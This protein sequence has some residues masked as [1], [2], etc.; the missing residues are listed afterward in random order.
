[1][2]SSLL[3][4]AL[5]GLCRAD[6]ISFPSLPTARYAA[7]TPIST[8]PGEVVFPGSVFVTPVAS[9]PQI[10][11]QT[12]FI[13]ADWDVVGASIGIKTNGPLD[14]SVNGLSLDDVTNS[15]I[16]NDLF[17]VHS[18]VN[19]IETPFPGDG[20]TGLKVDVDQLVWYTVVPCPDPPAATPEPA[21]L[22]LCGAGLLGL[23]W[24][25]RRD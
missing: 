23:A 13:P 10:Y 25:M 1:M 14:L 19:V 5:T 6:L 3:L 7:T 11:Q 15:T 21:T 22:A 9:G 18:G 8:P 2:R 24:R 4:F 20:Q 16:L 12:F 17:A